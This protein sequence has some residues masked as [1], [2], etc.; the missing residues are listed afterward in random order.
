MRSHRQAISLF[1]A[2]S[3]MLAVS[4]FASQQAVPATRSKPEPKGTHPW[5]VHEPVTHANLALF[6]V[7]GS[8]A[9][10][11]VDYLTLDEG[12]RAKT[13]EVTEQG[14]GLV[15]RR[16]GRPRLQGAQVNRLAL[17]NHSKQP[18]LLLAGEIVTGGKQDRVVSAD[19]IVPPG[20]E[21]PLDV[22]CVEPGRWNNNSMKFGASNMMAAPNIRRKAAVAKNQ[23]EVWAANDAVRVGA[24]ENMTVASG[25]GEGGGF[26]GGYYSVGGTAARTAAADALANS[27]SYKVLEENKEFKSIIDGATNRL[28]RDYEK[29]LKGALKGRKVTGVIVAINGEVVWADLFADAEL[30]E[31]YW[32][33]LMRSYVIEAMSVAAKESAT[34]SVHA[35]ESFLFELHEESGRQIIDTEP[36][37]FR[38]VHT[39]H[40]RYDAFELF[41]LFEKTEPLLHFSK[42][43]KENVERGK[44]EL[45]HRTPPFVGEQRR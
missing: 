13:V 27:S 1:V 5:Q 36:G 37:E 44:I 17:I 14:A 16:Q 29:A 30:F 9:T 19:R 43:R 22:F 15:R 32:P 41:S 35:A 38:L 21:L 18:L 42:L 2:I 6:P 12:L 33:K 7:T 23:Q 28:Q 45:M 34:A 24:M 11:G 3:V 8:V 31:H 25:S 26:G 4:A 20:A 10:A 39:D 40:A